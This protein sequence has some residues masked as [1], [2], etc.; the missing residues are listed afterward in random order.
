MAL[1]TWTNE[2]SVNVPQ[3]DEQHRRLFELTNQLHDAVLKKRGSGMLQALFAQVVQTTATHFA[4]EERFMQQ[5]RFRGI[6]KHKAQHD[7][8]TTQMQELKTRI[9][10][11]AATVSLDVVQ[12]LKDWMLT[13]LLESD[14]LYAPSGVPAGRT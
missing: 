10:A 1:M 11:G 14:R 13:H 6:D 2:L 12:F 7:A 4:A 3:M 5:I 9:E 8:W